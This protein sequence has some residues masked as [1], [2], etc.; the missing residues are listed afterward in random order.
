MRRAA[1]RHR[2]A[3]SLIEPAAIASCSGGCATP[4]WCSAIPAGSRRKRRRS[5]SRCWCCATRPSG[6]RASPRGTSRLVGTDRERDR[7]RGPAA[8][9]QP[10]RAR[11][12][13]PARL[14]RSA[15][16]TPDHASPRSSCRLARTKIADAPARLSYGR[17]AD[18]RRSRHRRTRRGGAACPAAA[19]HRLSPP[20]ADAAVALA[21]CADGVRHADERADDLQRPPAPLLGTVRREL[22]SSLAVVP[23]AADPRLGDDPLDLQSCRGAALAPRFRLAAGR[24][25]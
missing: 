25:R 2:A 3:S 24:R 22:R 4:T 8:A 10:G 5:A 12:D 23:R 20:P 17:F 6:P 14:S 11:G 13:E 1:R 21:Q 18:G 16:A 15:M 19:P 9:R 7:R